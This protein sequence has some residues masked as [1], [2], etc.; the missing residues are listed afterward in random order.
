MKLLAMDT[1]NQTLTVAVLEDEQVLAH[2]QLN[3]KMN[4]SLTLMPAIESVMEASG[5]KPADLDRI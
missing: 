3:R 4:H 2:F 5:S 1:S